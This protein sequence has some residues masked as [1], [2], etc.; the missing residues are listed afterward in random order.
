M[1]ITDRTYQ[2]RSLTANSQELA[3]AAS[4]CTWLKNKLPASLE[5]DAAFVLPWLQSGQ[6]VLDYRCGSGMITLELA[7]RVFP[8]QVT[9]FDQEASQLHQAER[10]AFGLEQVNASFRC[11]DLHRLPYADH[12]FDL[13]LALDL[14]S[15]E[16]SLSEL[17][18]VLRPDGLLALSSVSQKKTMPRS[19]QPLPELLAQ[20]A[21]NGFDLLTHETTEEKDETN[22]QSKKT[23]TTLVA[24]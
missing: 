3:R 5:S 13:I 8:G 15:P 14:V 21:L 23:R 2:P 20:L 19:I 11:G 9:G 6:R 22:A 16:T 10:L 4:P 18:R 12:S 7:R 24:I 1:T 17:R